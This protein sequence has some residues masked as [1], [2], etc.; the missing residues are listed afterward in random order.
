MMRTPDH[1]GGGHQGYYRGPVRREA[2]G[3]LIGTDS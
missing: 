2:K 1:D 3:S